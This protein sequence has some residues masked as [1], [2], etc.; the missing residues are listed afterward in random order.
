MSRVIE[1]TL[2]KFNELSDTAKERARDW[3]RGCIESDELTDYDDWIA[4]G[5]ILGV[6]FK[7]RAVPLMSGKTRY[8]PC[9]FWSCS[10]SQG[11]GAC[12]EGSY[13][14]AKLAGKKIR[15]HASLDKE[16]HRIA[17]ELTAIQRRYFYKIEA[18]ITHSG[19]YYHSGC[20]SVD[21]STPTSDYFQSTPASFDEV[22][23]LLRDFADWIFE[24]IQAQ[25]EYL[26]SEEAIDETM[27]CNDYEFDEN[28]KRT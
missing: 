5:D 13:A 22:K 6:T 3:Y 28:G 11:D 7:Q 25:S 27:E 19:H 15:K 18:K 17:D 12:F 24:K 16:L 14:Y 21:V 10:Y 4:I 8:D 9:I 23:Q 2:Y 20:M 1:K 26:H